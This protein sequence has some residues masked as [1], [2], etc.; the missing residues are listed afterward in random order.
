M[1]CAVG[2]L[3]G[4][5][6]TRIFSTTA[7]RSSFWR[8][9]KS[10]SSAPH[11]SC[12]CRFCDGEATVTLFEYLQDWGSPLCDYV[13]QAATVTRPRPQICVRGDF[14]R[15]SRGSSS[16]ADVILH[17][18][19]ALH[20]RTAH[21]CRCRRHPSSAARQRFQSERIKIA[22]SSTAASAAERR[23]QR[24]KATTSTAPCSRRRPA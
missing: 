4:G 5:R 13:D 8:C 14:V 10:S 11:R 2:Y 23:V 18:R 15:R 21:A 20:L 16:V 12:K 1:E 3:D 19:Q 7:P 6:A 9:S 17:L 22:S 24:L